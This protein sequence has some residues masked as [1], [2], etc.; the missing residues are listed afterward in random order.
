MRSDANLRRSECQ[1]RPRLGSSPARASAFSHHVRTIEGVTHVEVLLGDG[2]TGA[3]PFWV[4]P[5][6]AD[7][8]AATASA[9]TG[10]RCSYPVFSCSA[11]HR[12][13]L[14]SKSMSDQRSCRTAPMR[15][16]VSFASTSATWKR[17]STSSDTFSSAWYSSSE[18]T[19]RVGF[20]SVGILRPLNGFETRSGRPCSSL[21]LAAYAGGRLAFEFMVLTAA[22]SNEV[23]GATWDQIEH[24][25]L[26]IPASRMKGK[27]EHRVPLSRRALEI[28]E[29]ARKL[30]DEGGIVFRSARRG[31]ID[32]SMFGSL[33]RRL[34]V[35]GT[36][37]GMRSSFRDWCSE[38]GVAREV[39]EAWAAYLPGRGAGT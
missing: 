30:H 37:H 6:R 25:V 20:F 1:P 2:M 27:R 4:L 36:P 9:V 19:T 29:E 24:D 33:L 8:N 17:Q 13:V 12:M 21:D 28:L 22:R 16:P 7:S 10:V 15:C 18:R 14:P 11:R 38:T 5:L 3:S 31:G 34:G 23:R 35:D 39:M 26:T 32:A